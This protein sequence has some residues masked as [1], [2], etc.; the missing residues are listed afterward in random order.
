MKVLTAGR[1]VNLDMERSGAAFVFYRYLRDCSWAA[2]EQA[3]Q[4]A[5][6]FRQG[7]WRWD[8]GGERPWDS[9]RR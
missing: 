5:L 6:R 9:S 2:Y 4:Q 8:Q 3:K 1:D 7:V